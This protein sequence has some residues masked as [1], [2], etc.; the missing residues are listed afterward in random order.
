M[1]PIGEI[2]L[3]HVEHGSG[4]LTAARD[5][6]TQSLKAFRT[7]AVP[8]GVGNALT[9]LAE[10]AVQDDADQAERLLDEAT[11]ALH[12]AGPFY[13]CLALCGRA[14]LA[15][16]RG[17][18]SEAIALVRESLPHIRQLHDKFAFV[19]AMAILSAAVALRGDYVGAARLIGV[20][21]VVTER[22][23]ATVVG[24]VRELRD[25]A[26]SDAR[27]RLDP[28]SWAQAYA[29]GRNS[30]VE[31]LMQDIDRALM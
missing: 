9:G 27:A 11:S 5:R 7:L 29:T 23:G 15:V 4:N 18:A 3:G 12:Q 22:T 24:P 19:R 13:L 25:Q 21:D 14:M 10:L 1:L 31:A 8:W 17:N 16:R 28:D 20:H 26:E 2:V 6:F 30:S